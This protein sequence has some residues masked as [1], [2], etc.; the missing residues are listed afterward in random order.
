[1][2]AGDISRDGGRNSMNALSRR[3]FEFFSLQV[4]A[5][6]YMRLWDIHLGQCLLDV[7]TGHRLGE[8]VVSLA[9]DP[10]DRWIATADSSGFIKVRRPY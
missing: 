4:Y 2:N 10:S 6:R 7:F 8:T 5:D 1:M 3:L 9:V